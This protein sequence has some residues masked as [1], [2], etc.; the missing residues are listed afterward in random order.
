MSY[1]DIIFAVSLGEA[2]KI[3][4]G[5]DL[6]ETMIAVVVTSI[7]SAAISEEYARIKDLIEAKPP[8]HH[9]HGTMLEIIE[10][11]RPRLQ[12]DEPNAVR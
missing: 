3:L 12:G 2:L 11:C 9:P 8:V 1:S 7:R 10:T 5:T 6:N 4:R